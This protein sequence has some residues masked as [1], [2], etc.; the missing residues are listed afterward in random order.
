MQLEL[1]V[2]GSD[3]GQAVLSVQPPQVEEAETGAEAPAEGAAAMPA[4]A[5][6]PKPESE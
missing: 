5:E 2:S 6:T 3:P 1:L 4:A